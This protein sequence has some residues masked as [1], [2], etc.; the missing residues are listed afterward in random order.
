ML[1]GAGMDSSRNQSHNRGAPNE[2]DMSNM[3]MGQENPIKKPNNNASLGMINLNPNMDQSVASPNISK[4]LGN[5]TL[6]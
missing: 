1:G 6:N 5:A 4:Q 3:Q 2:N